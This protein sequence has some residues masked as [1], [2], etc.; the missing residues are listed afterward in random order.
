MPYEP[1]MEHFEKL[2]W[3]ETRSITLFDNNDFGLP[4]DDYGLL[5]S[6][7]DDEDC[8]CRRVFL[9]IV[10]RKHNKI[11]AVVTYGWENEAFYYK[12]F[13]GVDSPFV[14][15]A[16]KE[17]TGLGLNSASHQ[18]KLAPAIMKMVGWALASDPAYVARLK[19][20]YQMFK[21]KVDP[22]HFRKRKEITKAAP[23][24]SRPHHRRPRSNDN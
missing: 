24:S 3:K 4:P 14:H 17:M 10:S 23:V 20:H 16:V 15:Q 6:Y 8:D 12:W 9:N 11:M 5:E 7:C 21:E 13:G 2:G 19:R 1:F 18:S 22:K